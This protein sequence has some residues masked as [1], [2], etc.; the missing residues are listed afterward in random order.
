MYPIAENIP[1]LID[2]EFTK[3]YMHKELAD[4]SGSDAKYPIVRNALCF[5]VCIKLTSKQP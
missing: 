3:R 4:F 2:V 1:R 5:F